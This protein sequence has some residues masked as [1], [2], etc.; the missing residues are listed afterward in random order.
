MGER[1]FLTSS[2]QALTFPATLPKNFFAALLECVA[3]TVLH[4]LEQ[5]LHWLKPLHPAPEFRDL[6]LGEWV[7][8]FRWRRAGREP[9]KELAYFLQGEPRLSSALHYS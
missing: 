4:A 6:S 2:F 9:E 5:C 8:A 1:R 3:A 7:P